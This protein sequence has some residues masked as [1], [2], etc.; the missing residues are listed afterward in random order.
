MKDKCRKAMW[1]KIHKRRIFFKTKEEGGSFRQ[2]VP[3]EYASF[4][5]SGHS[6]KPIQRICP[7]TGMEIIDRRKGSP[8]LYVRGHNKFL[9]R[10]VI[11]ISHFPIKTQENYEYSI[12]I[13]RI[14]KY[15]MLRRN[16]Q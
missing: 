11:P 13:K 1:A 3:Y 16:Y 5:S 9:P 10:Y 14:K 12:P 15:V 6:F 4:D 7:E 8:I 2:F